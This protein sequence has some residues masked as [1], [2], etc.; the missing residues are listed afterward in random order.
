LLHRKKKFPLPAV[1][2][3]NYLINKK[4]KFDFHEPLRA[5][6]ISYKHPLG[7]KKSIYINVIENSPFKDEED[8]QR[9]IHFYVHIGT[10]TG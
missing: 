4:I 2:N 10:P 7:L 1:I 8:K 3:G 9:N 6:K 5:E